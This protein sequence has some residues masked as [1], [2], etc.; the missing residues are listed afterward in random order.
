MAEILKDSEHTWNIRG[1]TQTVEAAHGAVSQ[2]TVAG[3]RTDSGSSSQTSGE[4]TDQ[5]AVHIGVE[6]EVE[7]AIYNPRLGATT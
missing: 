3:A 7:L 4:R 2:S 6:F 5:N 1:S